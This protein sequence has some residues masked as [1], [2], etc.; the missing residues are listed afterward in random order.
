M[1][2]R[3]YNWLS[4]GV[5]ELERN[6][7]SFQKRT[8]GSYTNSELLN[9]RAFIAFCHAEVE[10]YFESLSRRV[11]ESA[12]R[13]WKRTGRTSNVI[14][15]LL[16][17]R[18]A[19]DVVIPENPVEQAGRSKFSSLI[20]A[21]IAAQKSAITANHGVKPKNISEMFIPL[22]VDVDSIDTNLMIQLRNFGRIRGDQVHS[23]S[24]VS[25]TK[26]RDPFDDELRDVNFLLADLKDFDT[27]VQQLK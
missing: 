3:E 19:S 27:I 20:G 15:A 13:Q 2:T 9:C 10:D 18:G 5:R 4:K 1:P 25:L 16:A 6:F 12:E 23:G 22:G 8:D 26:I 7:L 24:R 17:Y 21:A 11:V 14:S